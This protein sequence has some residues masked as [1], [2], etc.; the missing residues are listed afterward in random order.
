MRRT[1]IIFVLSI[2]MITPL[3]GQNLTNV[4]FTF[5]STAPDNTL[6]TME[7]NA[8]AVFEEINKAS[9]ENRTPR[10]SS[11]NITSDGINRI[12]ALWATSSFHFIEPAYNT[13][14]SISIR[15]QYAV[16]GI[17]VI[18]DEIKDEKKRWQDLVIEF[19]KETGKVSNITNVLEKHQY[20]KII[21]NNKVIDL[22]YRQYIIEFVEEFR[23]A[24]NRQDVDLIEKM[25]NDD[26]LIISGTKI[27]KII[28]GRYVT[29][30][31]YTTQ[32]KIQYINKLRKAI[33]PQVNGK[34]VN[35]INV[36]FEDIEVMQGNEEKV[37]LVKLWQKWD[38]KGQINYN[39]E[40]WLTL[41]ID[42]TNEEKPTIW[43]RAWEDLPR[44]QKAD[45]YD[46]NCFYNPNAC[47]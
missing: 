24:Y 15:N 17:S 12:L 9:N 38:S 3:L 4:I 31:T 43:V 18:F 22:R 11:A 44:N 34:F 32:N 41:V 29:R 28:D 36:D 39:D 14:V 8:K 46:F 40:G 30:S 45:T 10:F 1:G 37:Y 21:P 27:T 13:N 47:K 25:F 20:T 6:R 26:A 7:R 23:T 2:L 19:E 5:N 35:K 42:F 16:R 33:M